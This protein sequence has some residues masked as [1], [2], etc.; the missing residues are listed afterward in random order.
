MDGQGDLVHVLLFATADDTEAWQAYIGK[1]LFIRMWW[2]MEK[3]F[4][5]ALFRNG[6]GV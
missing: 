2:D 1:L 4:A 6:V 3:I 5:G